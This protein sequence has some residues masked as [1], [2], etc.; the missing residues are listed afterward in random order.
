[1]SIYCRCAEFGNVLEEKLRHT[2][3][4]KEELRE[5]VKRALRR[6]KMTDTVKEKLEKVKFLRHLQGH[7][8]DRVMSYLGIED[9]IPH[10]SKNN[11]LTSG[12]H[13]RAL[14]VGTAHHQQQQ[15]VRIKLGKRQHRDTIQP[16]EE[17]KPGKTCNQ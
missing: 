4:F 7:E 8:L 12:H 14:T 10:V 15:R 9:L 17:I 16:S 6:K 1:M 3:Y 2:D 11:A 5:K 13:Y